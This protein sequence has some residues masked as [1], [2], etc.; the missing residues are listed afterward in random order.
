MTN[1]DKISKLIIV[2][3]D[4]K[5]KK[6][7]YD[8]FEIE[9]LKQYTNVVIWDLSLLSSIKFNKGISASQYSGDDIKIISSYRKLILEFNKLLDKIKELNKKKVF[10]KVI[11][12]NDGI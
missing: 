3:V 6:F 9:Y 10:I 2:A 7:D 4:S 8:R 1:K 12:S 5:F 11:E